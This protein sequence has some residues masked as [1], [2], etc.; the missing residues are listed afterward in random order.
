MKNVGLFLGVIVG[1]FAVIVFMAM[2]FSQMT[3][4]PV[5]QEVLIGSARTAIGPADA[6]VTI[7]EF[8]DFQCPA[9]ASVEPLINGI[10]TQ[11]P[12]QVRFVYRHF[13]LESIH[14]YAV[15]VARVSEYALQEGLF[16]EFSSAVFANQMDWRT[17]PQGEMRTFISELAGEV[18]L[19][20][21]QAMTVLED[22]SAFE[23]VVR[24]DQSAGYR[25]GVNGTPTF[26]VNGELVQIGQLQQTVEN[27]LK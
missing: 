21:E 7:V 17:L 13:P 22:S 24:E 27:L 4:K 5:D 6:P 11:Y 8:S 26:Y 12:D 14:P 15:D 9:C 23:D 20:A 18:G 10:L 3:N 25:L 1:T 19:D 2:A 16:K